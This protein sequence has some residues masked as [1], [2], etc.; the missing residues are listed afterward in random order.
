[1]DSPV[2]MQELQEQ[3]NL[4]K[5]MVEDLR[6]EVQEGKGQVTR[7]AI[8]DAIELLF[9]P[10]ESDRPYDIAAELPGT[11]ECPQG[12][13]LGWKNLRWRER[14]GM[15]GW[16]EVRYGDEIAGDNG[17]NLTKYIKD[18]PSHMEG[19]AKIDSIVRRGDL[20]LCWIDKRVFMA[21]QLRRELEAARNRGLFENEQET[22]IRDGLKIFGPGLKRDNPKLKTSDS[23]TP[24][25]KGTGQG[26]VRSEL[27]D[28]KWQAE[29]QKRLDEKQ[30]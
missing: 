22:L 2:L 30:N 5:K 11:Q 19:S 18:P 1:M 8:E 15:R 13:V 9:D 7:N 14:R 17:V 26:T 25:E 29:T 16:V 23:F 3:L 21:R 4:Y 6:T 27:M 24:Y 12:R 20:A 10:Y 28:A